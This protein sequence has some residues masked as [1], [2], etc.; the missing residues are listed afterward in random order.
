MLILLKPVV[1]LR[2]KSQVLNLFSD[3]AVDL[4]DLYDEISLFLTNANDLC[5]LYDKI[6]LFLTNAIPISRAFG[7]MTHGTVDLSYQWSIDLLII[8]TKDHSDH[9]PLH[10]TSEYR[11]FR[12]M[13]RRTID[14]WDQWSFR[15]L[16][17]GTNDHSDYWPF[18]SITLRT[19][20]HSDHWQFESVPLGPLTIQTNDP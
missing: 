6:S 13:G 4:C 20:D 15:L 10:Y 3:S 19:T 2:I 11:L 5:N 17:I 16:P 7:P 12:P 14:Q 8:R 18:G 1:I 9:W